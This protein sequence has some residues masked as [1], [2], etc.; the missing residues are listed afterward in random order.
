MA[1][2]DMASME[3][4]GREQAW[5]HVTAA[6]PAPQV[7]AHGPQPKGDGQPAHERRPAHAVKAETGRRRCPG[8]S[9]GCSAIFWSM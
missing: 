3:L 2:P 6:Q 7:E 9:T 1:H 4:P 5:Q 8:S